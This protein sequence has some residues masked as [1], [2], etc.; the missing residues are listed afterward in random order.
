MTLRF[1]TVGL[2]TFAAAYLMAAFFVLVL[3]FTLPSSD[4]ASSQSLSETFDDPFVRL[5]AISVATVA[6]LVVFPFALFCLKDGDWL[7]QGVINIFVVAVFIAAVTPFAPAAAAF[8]SP[9]VA[10]LALFAIRLWFAGS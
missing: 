1:F 4:A 10:I 5:V 3:K 8:G 6:A 9:V 7:S 2:F